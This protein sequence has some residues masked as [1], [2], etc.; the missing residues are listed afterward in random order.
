[1]Y[2]FST[3]FFL[4]IFFWKFIYMISPLE[5]LV[6]VSMTTSSSTEFLT[7]R[8]SLTLT[9][10]TT[11]LNHSSLLPKTCIRPEN[12]D[13]ISFTILFDSYTTRGCYSAC[14]HKILM[15][16]KGVS[17][18]DYKQSVFTYTALHLYFIFIN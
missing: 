6:L 5:P 15:A 8:P 3:Y 7:Q 2:T 17:I 4:A 18:K 11:T 9:F 10:S 1:M 14:I 13:L 16:W 12:T